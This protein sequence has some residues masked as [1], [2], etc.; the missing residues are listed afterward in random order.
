MSLLSLRQLFARQADPYVG[1]DI[2]IANRIGG[3]LWLVMGALTMVA[4]PLAPPTARLGWPGW[5]VA[6]AI[7]AGSIAGGRALVRGKQVSHETLFKLSFLGVALVALLQWLAGSRHDSYHELY[8]PWALLTGSLNPPRRLGAFMLFLA[9]ASGAFLAYDGWDTRAAGEMASQLLIWTAIAIVASIYATSVRSQRAGLRQEGEDARRLARVDALTGLG[10]RRALEESL[11]A[12]VARCERTGSTLSV[13]VIDVNGFKGINDRHGHLEGDR[14]LRRVADAVRSSLREM[15]SGFR[16]GGDEFVVLLPETD[17]VSA[18]AAADRLRE[19]M[20]V[21]CRE[22]T[23]ESLS[24]GCGVA[25]LEDGMSA[26]E[27]LTMADLALVASK[28][29]RSAGVR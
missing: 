25:Q 5:L 9:A 14:C 12:E 13:L 27:L 26:N 4:A 1:S 19:G 17:A 2:V 29:R 11:A 16:W 6:A 22:P 18:H 20:V 3:I 28:P 15:D 10:N 8:L 23:G 21:T 7:V 24:I